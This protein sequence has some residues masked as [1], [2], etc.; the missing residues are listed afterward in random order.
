MK[1]LPITACKRDVPRFRA[2][3]ERALQVSYWGRCYQVGATWY[4]LERSI[5]LGRLRLRVCS[6]E[7]GGSVPTPISVA[8][9]DC[10][11]IASHAVAE[12]LLRE[13]AECRRMHRRAVPTITV[14]ADGALYVEP[15]PLP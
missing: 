8:I 9:E 1:T 10:A 11:Y 7:P 15:R 3:A 4:V 2:Y 6:L 12:R 5:R 13:A 14:G